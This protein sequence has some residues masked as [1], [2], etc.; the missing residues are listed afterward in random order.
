L[1]RPFQVL[2]AED[3]PSA[4]E[5][6]THILA[7]D[8]DI[9]VMGTA[10]DGIEAVA[11]AQ[12]RRPDVITMD[13]NMP[14]LNGLEATRQIMATFPCPIVIVSADLDPA[15]VATTFAALEAGALAVFRRPYGLGHPEHEQSATELLQTVK[16][17]AEVK[18]VKRWPHLTGRTETVGGSS[19]QVPKAFAEAGVEMVAMGAST[20]G[21]A[22]LQTI[23]EALPKNFP[24]P[25]VI[26]QHIASGFALGFAEWLGKSTGF[27][28]SIPVK[29]E[30]LFPGHIYV[31][32]DDVHLAV[33]PHHDLF[34]SRGELE[35][36]SRP[37][38]DHLFRSV[39]RFYAGRAVG[40][41]LTGMGADGAIG[42]LEMRQR[43]ALTLVQNEES[44][45]VHG[46]PGE[47]IKV[48][49]ASRVLSPSQIGD[50]LAQIAAPSK[51]IIRTGALT[52]DTRQ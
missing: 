52:P 47:A 14:R 46:M 48:G 18:V 45:V 3:S 12:N 11:L 1:K 27:P 17:M 28:V 23:L 39:A 42:L 50:A 36:G 29:R 15:E 33:G 41:L 40:V 26:V 49:A 51:P 5:F 16:L 38:I 4:R 9:Q 37:S 32:P 43:G 24:A 20:G 21:P 44:S 7:Q 8:P 31:A 30:A 34:V 19:R 6:L 35:S 13:I 10:V 25:I 2:V 22:V